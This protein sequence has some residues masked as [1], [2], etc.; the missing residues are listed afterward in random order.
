M[1]RNWAPARIERPRLPEARKLYASLVATLGPPPPGVHF[2]TP[3]VL[4]LDGTLTPLHEPETFVEQKLAKGQ[5][6]VGQ[7]H[8]LECAYSGLYTD[9][10]LGGW[11]S[12]NDITVARPLFERF[13][14]LQWNPDRIAMTTDCGLLPYCHNGSGGRPGV[15]RAATKNEKVLLRDVHTAEALSAKISIW[16]QPNEWCNKTLKYSWPLSNRCA[17]WS[18]RLETHIDIEICLRLSNARTRI[19]GYNQCKTVFRAHVDANFKEQLLAARNFAHY[20]QMRKEHC[21]R[22]AADGDGELAYE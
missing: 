20:V 2:A 11:G 18:E 19:V 3:P 17:L 12:S 8:V 6:G 13:N 7:N 10:E 22:L 4:M 14:S 5:K 15:Y 16:R 21:E 9:F 1:L